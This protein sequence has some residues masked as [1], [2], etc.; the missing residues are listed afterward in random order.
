MHTCGPMARLLNVFLVL[1]WLCFGFS[2][3]AFTFQKVTRSVLAQRLDQTNANSVTFNQ[4]FFLIEDLVRGDKQSAPV[5]LYMC[6]HQSCTDS[7]VP[8]GVIEISK[9]LGSWIV[10]VEQR[11]RGESQP[12]KDLSPQSMQFLTLKNVLHDLATFQYAASATYKLN[13]P[14]IAYGS[15]YGGMMAAFYRAMYP[16]MVAAAVASSAVIF[17]SLEI[18][19]NDATIGSLI[20]MDCSDRFRS[21]L[22]GVTPTEVS[23]IQSLSGLNGLTQDDAKIILDRNTLEGAGF[24][25]IPRICTSLSGSQGNSMSIRIII[26][27]LVSKMKANPNYYVGDPF[28]FSNGM[29]E[30][31]KNDGQHQ[32][33]WQQATELGFLQTSSGRGTLPASINLDYYRDLFRRKFG[34]NTLPNPEKTLAPYLE[35]ILRGDEDRI[36][37]ITYKKDP[38]YEVQ[39]NDDKAKQ[40]PNSRVWYM[41]LQD[42]FHSKDVLGLPEDRL[43]REKIVTFIKK[44]IPTPATVASTGN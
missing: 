24:G 17:P 18:T 36:L 25:K 39:F 20:G 7:D 42:G 15:S 34:I 21:A 19:S 8:T 13:G 1:T 44:F 4:R 14:W 6:A 38:W 33:L 16:Q 40:Y 37:F 31:R 10:G 30:D 26:G 27:W 5:V 3:E 29:N 9:R 28:D 43:L 2:A 22:E 23:A 11:Y 41:E 12:F 32:W 35:R